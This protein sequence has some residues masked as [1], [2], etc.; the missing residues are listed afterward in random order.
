MSPPDRPTSALDENFPQPILRK[1]IDKYVLAIEVV[2]LSELDPGLLGAYQDDELISELARRRVDGLI[3]CDDNMVFR[4]EVL[5]VVQRTRFSVV[6][7]R[8]VG[9]DPIRASGLLLVHLPDIASRHRSDRP[10]I[11]RLGTAQA[12]PLEFT[13]HKRIVDDR[14]RRPS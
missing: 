8:R 11:W 3:T 10:Q 1:A 5:S 4:P 7:C 12:R 14:A 2:P 13:E 9:D 6:T